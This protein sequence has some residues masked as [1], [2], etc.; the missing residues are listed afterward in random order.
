LVEDGRGSYLGAVVERIASAHPESR[1][2]VQLKSS[3]GGSDY[4][5]FE[6]KGVPILDFHTGT[7]H[8]EYHRATDSSE[9]IEADAEARI[10]RL[11]FYVTQEVANA[12]QRPE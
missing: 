10:L 12:D 4:M 3:P 2:I 8:P 6:R 9:K 11:V 1:L 5:S 7:W